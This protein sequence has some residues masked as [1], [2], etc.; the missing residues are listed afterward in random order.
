[1]PCRRRPR[2]PHR[3]SRHRASRQLTGPATC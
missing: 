1:M 2:R 3:L